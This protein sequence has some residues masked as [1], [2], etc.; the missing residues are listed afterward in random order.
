MKIAAIGAKGLPGVS[1]GIE[2]HTEELYSR[3]SRRGHDVTVYCRPYFTPPDIGDTYKGIKIKRL[4]SLNTKHLD[5]VSHTLIS[6]FHAVFTDY[7][8]V[9]IHGIGPA[10]LSFIPKIGRAKVCVTVHALDWRR[11]KWGG[12]AKAFL[13]MGERSTV[14]FPDAVVVVS[15]ELENYYQEKYPQRKVVYIPNGVEIPV[16]IAVDFIKEKFTLQKNRYL[17]FVGRLVPEKGCLDLI[18]AFKNVSAD[19]KLVIAG[20]SSHTDAYEEELKQA[21]DNDDRV[22][23]TGFISG[24]PLQELYSNAYAFILPSTLEGLPVVL[25]EALSYGLPVLASDIAPNREIIG[26]NEN[27]GTL[28]KAGDKIDLASK[29]SFILTDR[30]AIINKAKAAKEF[31]LRSYD[32]EIVA[33]STE[34]LY[35]SL[36]KE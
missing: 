34:R 2:R 1:G 19:L 21:A 3:L 35:L 16:P 24:K 36:V 29:L 31:V 28:F 13:K 30:S 22:I 12:L 32:W 4:P 27:Y 33:E 17:L 23:F 15:R 8:I 9:H 18:K 25:L 11:E 6:A 7:D 5:A 26:D 10:A 14:I 20:G